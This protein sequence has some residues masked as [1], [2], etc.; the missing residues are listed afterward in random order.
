VR[1]YW[2]YWLC[3]FCVLLAGCGPL[4]NK[5]IISEY[6]QCKDAGMDAE[7]LRNIDGEIVEVQCVPPGT[8]K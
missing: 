8:E 6:H 2:L 7:F 3:I 4:T 1:L 5:A